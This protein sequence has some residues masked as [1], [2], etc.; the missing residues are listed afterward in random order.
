MKQRTFNPELWEVFINFTNDLDKM[1]G[2]SVVKAVP[3]LKEHF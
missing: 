3:Q 2:D 1:R